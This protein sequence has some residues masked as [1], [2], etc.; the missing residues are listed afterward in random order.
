MYVGIP[1]DQF[2]LDAKIPAWGT[3][4]SDAQC[5]ALAYRTA[6]AGLGHVSPNPLVGCVI[7]DA[8]GHLLAVGAHRRYG[9]AHAEVEAVTQAVARGGA[10]CMRGAR[11]FVTLQPCTHYGKTPPCSELLLRHGVQEVHFGADDPNPQVGSLEKLQQAGIACH[12][13]EQSGTTV[14][15]RGR[16]FFTPKNCAVVLSWPPRLPRVSMAVLLH[17]KDNRVS[18]SAVNVPYSMGIFCGS[19]YDAILVGAGTLQT[20]QPTSQCAHRACR[21][22]AH[23]SE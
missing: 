23:Q 20:R 12:K 21:R 3:V 15:R 6:L 14:A 11:L 19:V 16:I 22:H 5:H 2:L 13:Y 18:A 10:E 7:T 4:L 1:E 17:N 8:Q 9:E